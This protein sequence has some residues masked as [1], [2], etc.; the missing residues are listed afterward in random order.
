MARETTLDHENGALKSPP[1]A[2]IGNFAEFVHDM[3]DLLELQ[4]KLLRFDLNRWVNETKLPALMLASGL[5][6]LLSGFPVAVLGLGLLLS[7][8]GGLPR[9]LAIFLAAGIGTAAGGLILAGAWTMLR[10]RMAILQR[11]QEEFVTNIQ[12]VKNALKRK[13]RKPSSSA[14]SAN[15]RR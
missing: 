13:Q 12:S 14:E 5:V 7:D 6:I 2:V 11:S 4:I 1:Q 8:V 9:W 10:R 3:L 15:F